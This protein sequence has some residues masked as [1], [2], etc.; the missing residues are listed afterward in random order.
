MKINNE[1]IKTW[2]DYKKRHE[3]VIEGLKIL[4]G[5]LSTNCMVPI[6]KLA[7]MQGKLTHTNEIMVC[8][9]DGYF[10]KY[11]SAQAIA[12]CNRRIKSNY[13]FITYLLIKL[14]YNLKFLCFC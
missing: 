2:N 6:G 12:L 4:P 10:A 7:L 1:Q 5:E 9:G 11:T 14:I 8:L 3:K 13:Y